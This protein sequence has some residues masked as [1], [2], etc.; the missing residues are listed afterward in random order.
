ML[1]CCSFLPIQHGQSC[2]A[3]STTRKN[4]KRNEYDFSFASAVANRKNGT[5]NKQPRKKRRM[6]RKENTHNGTKSVEYVH[7]A[8]TNAHTHTHLYLNTQI[9]YGFGIPMRQPKPKTFIRIKNLWESNSL[10]FIRN[11]WSTRTNSV[12]TFLRNSAGWL[13]GRL[14]DSVDWLKLMCYDIDSF[15]WR[16]CRCILYINLM[17]IYGVK[18]A[19]VLI[20][21]LNMPRHGTLTIHLHSTAQHSCR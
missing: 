20:R 10:I 9:S 14:T 4:G 17:I 18:R 15:V 19:C 13:A 2:I 21:R 6:K 12:A 16:D 11:L 7:C 1:P 8:H 3:P 5:K